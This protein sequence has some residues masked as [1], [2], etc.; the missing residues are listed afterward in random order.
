MR[1]R[2]A[3]GGIVHWQPRLGPSLLGIYHCGHTEAV[4]PAAV[5]GQ[6]RYG[7][8]H[9]TSPAGHWALL[10]G[11]LSLRLSHLPN[12]SFFVPVLLPPLLSQV[13]DLH[14][15]LKILTAFFYSLPFVLH[16]HFPQYIFECL[17]LLWSLVLENLNWHTSN[18]YKENDKFYKIYILV[19]MKNFL[20]LL[21]LPTKQTEVQV[22]WVSKVGLESHFK[23]NKMFEHLFHYSSITLSHEEFP[24]KNLQTEEHCYQRYSHN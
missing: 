22:W 8:Q 19:C 7:Y 23:L 13:S 3:P 2:S 12:S 16:R 4:L 6:V 11:D 24:L 15:L 18:K 10:M 21:S 9:K 1:L 14:C 20:S 17:I 5:H